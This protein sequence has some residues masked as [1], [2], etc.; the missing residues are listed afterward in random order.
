MAKK[1][2]KAVKHKAE[3]APAVN[4]PQ[5]T[6]EARWL[7]LTGTKLTPGTRVPDTLL[8]SIDTLRPGQAIPTI[9][10]AAAN[11]RIVVVARRVQ[12]TGCGKKA[13][14]AGWYEMDLAPNLPCIGPLA[15]KAFL[16]KVAAQ[17]CCDTLKCPKECPCRYTPQ[18]ALAIYRCTPGVKEEGFLL[19]G[20]QVWN[21]ECVVEG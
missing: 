18:A 20:K 19:Q 8:S 6:L 3:T 13:E 11:P 5:T 21:C 15:V 9:P 16:D 7:E 12:G 1:P 10:V 2:Q 14:I 17:V 4:K